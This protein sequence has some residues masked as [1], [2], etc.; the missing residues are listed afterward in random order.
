MKYPGS[1]IKFCHGDA[2]IFGAY[3]VGSANAHKNMLKRKKYNKN[4]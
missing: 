1:K 4:K 2:E 3:Y